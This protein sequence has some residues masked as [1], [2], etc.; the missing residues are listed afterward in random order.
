MISSPKYLIYS[1]DVMRKLLEKAERIAR[2]DEP[3]LILGETGTGKEML[4]R[5]IHDR[6]KRAGKPFLPLN[7]TALPDSLLESELFGYRKGAF[8]DARSDKIG[9]FEAAEGGTIF[10]DE[11]G[12]LHPQ[13]QVKLLRVLETHEIL[14]LGGREPVHVDFRLIAATNHDLIRMKDEGKF[15]DDLFYRIAV[16]ILRIPPLRERLDEIVIFAE[17]FAKEVNPHAKITPEVI[18]RLLCHDW[19]GN[20]RELRNVIRHAILLA[21]DGLVRVHHLPDWFISTCPEQSVLMHGSLKDRVQC[22][23]R[24]LL[25]RYLDKFDGNVQQALQAL[26]IARSSFYRK[27]SR[28]KQKKKDNAG[29]SVRSNESMVDSGAF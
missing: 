16:F 13:V 22:F 21:E 24:N 6:S 12:D 20:I 25:L 26:G 23:E 7:C 17:H 19:P 5:W 18:E 3:I 29:H 14:P 1:S 2:T 10:L 27:I 9:L 15:R 11:I 4:A 28:Q 8:T